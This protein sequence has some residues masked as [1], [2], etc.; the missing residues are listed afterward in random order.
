MALDTLNSTRRR[1][2]KPLQI[3]EEHSADI[4]S[5]EAS[6]ELIDVASS[7]VARIDPQSVYVRAD[8]VRGND[9]RFLLM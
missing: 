6:A 9:E 3:Q 4:V 2:A 8:L 7:V 1:C 5:V